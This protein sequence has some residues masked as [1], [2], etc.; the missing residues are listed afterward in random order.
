M[1]DLSFQTLGPEQRRVFLLLGSMIGGRIDL[2]GAAALLG[3]P[4]DDTDDVLQEL[5]GGCLLEEVMGDVYRFHDLIGTLLP[6]V[7]KKCP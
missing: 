5:V 7:P 4:A 2:G 3:L 1:I 6:G